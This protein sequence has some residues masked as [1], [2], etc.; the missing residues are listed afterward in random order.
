MT[1]ILKTS[2]VAG[3]VALVVATGSALVMAHNEQLPRRVGPGI[4][5]PPPGGPMGG[6]RRGPG[7]PIGPMGL[8]GPEFRELDLTDDQRGQ[9]KAIIDSHQ[10]ELKV[11]AEKI[12]EA[13]EA[14]RQ[15]LEAESLDEPAVRAKS[16]DVAAADADAAILNAKIRTKTLAVLTAEQQQKLKELRE[17]RETQMKQRRPGRH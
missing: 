3:C 11:A 6:P 5:G 2:L 12:G 16:L 10:P 14:M 17:S 9:I 8:G 13:W 15:L 7:G 4:G 1:K